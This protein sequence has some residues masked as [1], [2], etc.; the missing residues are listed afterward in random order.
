MIEAERDVAPHADKIV[1]P[2][3][4]KFVMA[5]PH[6]KNEREFP[7][8]RS[9]SSDVSAARP[10]SAGGASIAV[11]HTPPPPLPGREAIVPS[12][13]PA[14]TTGGPGLAGAPPVVPGVPVGGPPT[15]PSASSP[16][17]TPAQPGFVIGSGAFPPAGGGVKRVVATT[18]IVGSPVGRGG[19][20]GAK[21]PTP[22][23]LPVGTGQPGLLGTTGQPNRGS[24]PRSGPRGQMLAGHGPATGRGGRRGH[25]DSRMD[26]DPDDPW[27]T[28]EGV[29][30]VIEPSRHIPRHDPGPGVIG[31]WE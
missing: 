31:P 8:S 17:F 11:P 13:P 18:P 20:S 4:Y 19:Y 27:A 15:L 7:Q 6:D 14:P 16:P 29:S 5:E 9:G 25:D 2:A 24:S 22:S 23:W 21:P 1:S 3:P 12:D 26:F 30:P 28:V 10:G